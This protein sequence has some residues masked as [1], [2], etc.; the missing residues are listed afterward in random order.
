M[1]LRALYRAYSAG[2]ES[3]LAELPLQ[4]ADYAVWQREWL[5]GEVLEAELGYWREQLGGELPV[6]E[7]P[8]DRP[9]S[10]SAELSRRA[11]SS[12]SLTKTQPEQLQAVEPSAGLHVVHDAAGGVSDAC[13]YRY[14]GQEEIIVGT[15]I[16][17][18]NRAEIE[19]LIGFFVNKLVL[20]TDFAADPSSWSCCSE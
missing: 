13:C 17:G 10:G 9:A 1:R 12:S 15:D 14:S 2:E 16:A 5:Q 8:T 7:L 11:C 20:R 19:P 4:Y 6:L 18:R 3:P